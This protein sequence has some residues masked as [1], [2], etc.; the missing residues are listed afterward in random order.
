MP[1]ANGGT[2]T[3]TGSITGTGAL[4][5]T[6]GGS[7][8][9]VNIT[10]SGTGTTV[11]GGNVGIGG[12]AHGSYKLII[13]DASTSDGTAGLYIVKSNSTA[14]ATGYGIQAYSTLSNASSNSYAVTGTALGV[15]SNYAITS[16]SNNTATNNIGLLGLLLQVL[17]STMAYSVQFREQLELTIKPVFFQ[18]L[19]P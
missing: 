17:Q 5:F 19:Q 3:S 4:T 14:S 13:T 16:N 2:G 18:I 11:L 15:G 10:P 1:V 12:S 6:A 8:Q 9:D 7:N